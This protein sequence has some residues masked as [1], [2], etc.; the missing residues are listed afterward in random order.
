[1]RMRTTRELSS[2]RLGRSQRSWNKTSFSSNRFAI[3]SSLMLADS[4]HRDKRTPTPCVAAG[5]VGV[6]VPD[7]CW[8]D[9]SPALLA[10]CSSSGRTS[11]SVS[12]CGAPAPI[13]ASAASV[14]S[15]ASAA[16]LA[17]C[18]GC[19]PT[20]LRGGDVG[21][22]A[23]WTRLSCAPEPPAEDEECER[24]CNAPPRPLCGLT[25][26]DPAAGVLPVL[27]VRCDAPTDRRCCCCCC[28]CC[29][30]CV[31]CWWWRERFLSCCRAVSSSPRSLRS[32][33]WS[34]D[35]SLTRRCWS[36]CN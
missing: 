9:S 2:S 35:D 10:A 4:P 30:C 20:A 7:R 24:A 8:S 15:V 26:D 6:L 21:V 11:E 3:S 23:E 31:P 13:T 22:E 14:A 16:S 17:P 12:T 33:R 28:C 36:C 1:M 34:A 29:S 32:S 18:S 19:R 27:R 5:G 25:D